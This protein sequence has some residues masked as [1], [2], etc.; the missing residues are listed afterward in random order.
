MELICWPTG[1]QEIRKN[2]S[3]RFV[4]G[5][6]VPVCLAGSIKSFARLEK[7]M[8]I[9]PWTYTIGSAFFENEFGNMSIAD[10]IRVVCDYMSK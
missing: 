2:L 4:A 7:I 3:A 9:A 6:N 1:I 8:E 10:Q 5:V